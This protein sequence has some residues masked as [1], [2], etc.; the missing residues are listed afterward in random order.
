M[1]VASNGSWRAAAGRPRCLTEYRR[2]KA[3]TSPTEASS[4]RVSIR[5]R[6][7]CCTRAVRGVNRAIPTSD[8]IF[9]VNSKS[10]LIVKTWSDWKP[11][12]T[13]TSRTKLFSMSPAPTSRTSASAACDTTK[14]SLTR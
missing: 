9:F 3:E 6:S 14:T 10:N 7:C 11:G 4:G 8:P 5:S 12:S 13:R 1:Y 2:S